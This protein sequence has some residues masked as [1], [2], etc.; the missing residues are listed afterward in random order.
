V[1][2]TA[3]GYHLIQ[4]LERNPE[5]TIP[6][7]KVKEDVAKRSQRQKTQMAFDAY[8]EELKSKAK[9]VYPQERPKAEAKPQAAPAAT[10]VPAAVPAPETKPAEK[11]EVPPAK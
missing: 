10:A 8:V 11:I 9:I 6:L 5:N 7:E 2:E 1:V 3:F 4:V